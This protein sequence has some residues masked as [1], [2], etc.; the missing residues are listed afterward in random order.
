MKGGRPVTPRLRLP[1]SVSS[2]VSSISS[3]IELSNGNKDYFTESDIH[4]DVLVTFNMPGGVVHEQTVNAGETVQEIKRRLY[5]SHGLP[6]GS[7]SLFFRG[8]WLLDPLSL[9][10]IDG[11][12]ESG[13]ALIEV[14]IR[15]PITPKPPELKHDTNNTN[16]N[17]TNTNNT[18]T[19]NTN[20]HNT[21]TS[22]KL[23]NGNTTTDTR[24]NNM[25]HSYSTTYKQEHNEELEHQRGNGKDEKSTQ[26]S[27]P[28]TNPTTNVNIST[29]IFEHTRQYSSGSIEQVDI[30]NPVPSLPNATLDESDLPD[31][32][33]TNT[34]IDMHD[35]DDCKRI[36]TLQK[37][38]KWKFCFLFW[39]ALV[40]LLL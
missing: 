39:T 2:S 40:L 8:R 34:T 10:D 27:F 13:K 6:F 9:N 35:E 26:P 38:R 11:L 17:N 16:T 15:E 23:P 5:A 21:N 12:V 18:N 20:A 7:F 33:R 14:K 1:S 24:I 36:E 31:T 3:S 37:E 32:P 29:R 30:S 4:D 28:Q 22:T 25:T 19:N